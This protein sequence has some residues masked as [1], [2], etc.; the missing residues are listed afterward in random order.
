MRL[1]QVAFSCIL[2]FFASC[3]SSGKKEEYRVARDSTWFPL[4]LQGRDKNMLAFSDDLA[5]EVNRRKGIRLRF[6][7][8]GPSVIE[9]GLRGGKFDA[10]L[11]TL[12]PNAFH[13]D[14]YR[15]SEPFF[16]T[17]EV[18]VVPSQS[19]VATLRDLANKRVGILRGMLGFYKIDGDNNIIYKQYETI[20]AA[21][22]DMLRD[23]LEGVIMNL[24]PASTLSRGIYGNRIKIIGAPLTTAGIRLMV[25]RG[26]N[27]VL[28]DRF[29][30]ALQGMLEDGTH[31]RL[32]EKW[33]LWQQDEI[34]QEIIN[35]EKA[36]E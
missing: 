21:I 5:R 10:A 16:F 27:E 13:K 9:G 14:L 4:Q 18:L 2:L 35:K 34:R 26:N 30:E 24:I 1:S 20:T 36:H 17:G 23:E 33:G 31:K 28:I 11:T 12:E 7:Q 25:L 8:V 22:E 3:G 29:N 19:S 6:L 15:F 32:R